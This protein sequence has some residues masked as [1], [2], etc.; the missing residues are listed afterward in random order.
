[1]L[2]HFFDTFTFN[3]T[4][5]N[6]QLLLLGQLFHRF[7][8]LLNINPLGRIQLNVQS[9]VNQVLRKFIRLPVSHPPVVIHQTRISDPVEPGAEGQALIDIPRQRLDHGL[10]DIRR[11]VF[12]GSLIME[13]KEAIAIN[14]LDVSV[15]KL[16]DCVNVAAPRTLDEF[17]IGLVI[18]H[19][20]SPLKG[21]GAY[22]YT[23]Y[24]TRTKRVTVTQWLDG[25]RW[26]A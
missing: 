21:K 6:Y 24:R 23:S 3:K 22:N 25:W 20:I 18:R 10:K 5:L 13:T 7:P 15:I 9:V 19:A 26:L 2:S 12:G 16:T 1:L 17:L 14:L 4:Q 11:E 8:D